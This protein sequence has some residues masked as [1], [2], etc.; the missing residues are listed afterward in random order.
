[1]L[2][3]K[4]LRCEYLE[5][6]IGLDAEK[7]RIS[8]QLD[9]DRRGVKQTAF[10]IQV[11]L[12]DNFSTV[13]W[14]SNRIVTDESLHF[15]IDHITLQP[16][17]RYYYRLKVW[18]NYNNESNWSEPA[19]WETGIYRNEN[20]SAEWITAPSTLENTEASPYFRRVFPVEKA[21]KSAR[22]YATS[23]G[24]YELHLNGRRVGDS[25]FTPGWTSYNKRLQYQAYDVTSMVSKG[26]NAIGMVLGNGWYKGQFGFEGRKNIYGDQKAGLLEL[27]ITFEDGEKIK[28]VTDR[29][30]QTSSGPIKM[31]EI[32]HGEHYDARLEMKDWCKANFNSESWE[33][34]VV[35]NHKKDMIVFQQNEPVRKIDYLKPKELIHSP[36][37]DI[38]LDM[39]QNMVGW[40][41][42]HIKGETGQEVSLRHAEILDKN[43]NFYLGNIRTAKQKITYILKGDEEG[44]TFEPHFTFQG[45]R[46]VK[47]IGF[48]E[49]IQL[50][51][52]TGVVLHSDMEETGRFE[53]SNPLINQLHHNIVWGQKG[54]FLDVPT[55]CP[56]RDERLGWTGDAQMFARTASY[57]KNIAPFFTKWMKDLEADQLDN[58]GVPYV[59]PDIIQKT[60]GNLG[61]VTHS[62]AAWGDAAVIIPWTIYLCYGDKQ[63]LE[64][65][66]ESMKAWVEYVRGRG[67][68]EEL[69][70]SDFQLG[71]WLA[72]D[73]E[74]DTY[75]GATDHTFIATAYFAYSAEL[76][77]RTAGVIDRQDDA[78]N[79]E[80]LHE[81]IVKAFQ[82]KFISSSG[83]LTV[84]TQTAHVLT[85]AF[86][87]VGCED[88]SQIAADLVELIKERDYHL[89]TGFVG[90]PYLNIVLSENGYHDVACKLLL[91][92][93]YPSWLY[94]ITKGATTVWEHWDSI[95][96]DGSFWSDDMNSFNHYAYGSIGEWLYK[97][98]GGIDVVE[99]QPGYKHIYLTPNLGAELTWVNTNLHTM[100][101]DVRSSWKQE[102]DTIKY[103][104]EIPANTT[105]T[106]ILKD[107]DNVLVKESGKPLD[108]QEGIYCYL[109]KDGY[110][111]IEI[112]SGNYEFTY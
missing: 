88:K 102:N 95:K 29:N 12:Q 33:N 41:K 68:T 112:G 31:S 4:S 101:G 97:V 32:Y 1:M 76:L 36:E 85:L 99:D 44:E 64:E 6:P 30:W 52:F 56:Q 90:T 34:A 86:N 8:W 103:Q 100:Y 65:Q 73:S 54:N 2:Q 98:I 27:H 51:D 61:G 22:I 17:T 50:D 63:I 16:F 106:I 18:D 70:D 42:F 28:V 14:D 109:K 96:E 84:Q 26:E 111:H 75:T 53:C 9:S 24:I 43:G 110:L 21:V 49:N 40:M 15:E 37:G 7:P 87:L 59:I 11:S 83:S 69:W 104:F 89:T 82:R 23:L 91:Q 25:Y 57:L 39:G 71:D 13:E 94:Q 72:L 5:N 35:I 74:P 67:D 79:Y 10:Q 45:F 93:D 47:L 38:V 60:S 78:R 55:D 108:N 3:V 81:K 105:A 48:P 80:H 58:G 66:Y 20:W 107:V 19:Y 92:T 62:V 77:A 46:Y